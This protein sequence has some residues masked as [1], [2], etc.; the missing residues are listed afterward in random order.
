MNQDISVSKLKDELVRYNCSKTSLKDAYARL[1]IV[2]SQE[3][4]QHRCVY[5]KD[6]VAIATNGEMMGVLYIDNGEGFKGY[7]PPVP[8]QPD[9]ETEKYWFDPGDISS[10]DGVVANPLSDDFDLTINE[11]NVDVNGESFK[12]PTVDPTDYESAFDRRE[13]R[14]NRDFWVNTRLFHLMTLCLAPGRE[15]KESSVCVKFETEG[16]QKAADPLKMLGPHG[17]GIYMPM[18]NESAQEITGV[19]TDGKDNIGVT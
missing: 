10:K 18:A 3:E 19:D 17:I 7:L 8:F 4:K 14:D 11:S 16:G 2:A 13:D 9:S 1:S 15:G 12:F 6:D 5:I